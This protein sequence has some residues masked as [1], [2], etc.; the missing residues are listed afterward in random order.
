MP[1]MLFLKTIMSY[2]HDM[3]RYIP[4]LSALQAFE[5]SAT[6]LNFTRA[7][8]ELGRTQSGVSRQVAN[9]ETLLG[10]ELFERF[11]PRL[12]LSPAGEAYA[13]AISDIL[14]LLEEAVPYP[15]IQIILLSPCTLSFALTNAFTAQSVISS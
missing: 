2:Y 3:R 7:G 14:N 1:K 9:L 8:E 10:I 4:S 6:T 5:A 12:V 13:A 15:R 11:G